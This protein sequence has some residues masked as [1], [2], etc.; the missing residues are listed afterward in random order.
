MAA[1][2]LEAQ[3]AR[4]AAFVRAVFEQGWNRQE[5]GFLDGRIAPRVAMSY[6]GRTMSTSASDLP[7]LVA[8]WR[9]AF[10]DLAFEVHE[11]IADG[12]R[13]AVRLTLRGSH[14]G[15]SWWGVP[16]S[17]RPIEVAELLVEM[18]ELFDEATLRAQIGA[19][20]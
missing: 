3:E 18:W 13:V 6:N 7:G 4:N 12:P 10:P 11:V 14:S 16:P 9:R 19:P 5:F 8:E 17:G 2:S 20:D 1:G 15:G